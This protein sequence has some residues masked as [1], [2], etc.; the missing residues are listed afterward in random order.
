VLE[1]VRIGRALA[2]PTRVRVLALLRR[3]E[4]C[5]CELTDVL[6]LTQSTLSTHLQA[7]RAAGLVTTRRA[8]KWVYYALAPEPAGL[9]ENL[10]QHCA[11]ARHAAARHDDARLRRRLALRE[12]G[13]C[14]VGFGRKGGR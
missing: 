14:Q 4:L 13:C 5:V 9:V 3:G 1:L 10:F 8:G 7:L 12:N 2:D 6:G 11:G